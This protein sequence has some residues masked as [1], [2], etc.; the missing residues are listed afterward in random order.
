[1]SQKLLFGFSALFLIAILS[2]QVRAQGTNGDPQSGVYGE[3]TFRKWGQM[4]GNLVNTPFI[5][6]GM[7]GNWPNNPDPA[8][9]PKGSGHTYVEGATPIV[10]AE[11]VDRDG[12]VV[13]IAEAGYREDIDVGPTGTPWGYEPRPGWDGKNFE[14]GPFPFG[15]NITPAMSNKPDSWPDVWPDKFGPEFADDPGWPGAWNGFFGKN[16]FNADLETFFVMDDASDREFNYLPVP[17]DPNRG[18]LGTMV[19]ARGLQWSQVLAEDV[20]F[21]V[22]KIYNIS[23]F[24]LGVV[25]A[26]TEPKVFFGMMF[27]YGIGGLGDSGD[28]SAFYD[29]FIDISYGFDRD[30]KGNTGFSPTAYAGFA[31]LESP[32]NP[33]DNEDNDDDGFTDETRESGPGDKIEG[34]DNITNYIQT[35]YDVENLTSFFGLEIAE[36]PAVKSGILWTG[37]EDLDWVGFSDL[38]SNGRWDSTNEPLNNDVGADGISN[39]DPGY[40]G[41]DFGEGDGMPTAG[42][43]NFDATDLD[44]SDQIGLT[45]VHIFVTHDIT[46]KTDDLIWDSFSNKRFVTDIQNSLA[47]L[48]YSSGGFSLPKGSSQ[49][50]SI[51]MLF[52]ENLD[53]LF[54]N[55]ITVQAIFNANYNFAKPPLKPFVSAVPGDGK[56]TLYWDRRAEESVD[57]FLINP[58]TGRPGAKDFEGYK[59][60]RSTEPA[61]LESKNIT[62]A[63]GN[64]TFR[65]AIATFDLVNGIKG[66]APVRVNGISFDLGNDSGLRHSFV[67]STVENGQTYYY[68]V[69]SY[70]RGAPNLGTTGLPPSESSSVIDIDAFGNVVGTDVNT[71][72][73]TPNPKVPGYI[74]PFVEEGSLKPAGNLITGSGIIGSGGIAGIKVLDE[75]LV[76]DRT[77]RVTF[78]SSD[79]LV[80]FDVNTLTPAQVFLT[81]SY[82]V[83]DVT[84]GADDLKISASNALSIDNEGP[85]FD[86][87]SLVVDNDQTRLDTTASAW[88]AGD[89]DFE[90]EI[91]LSGAN[92]DKQILYP[93]DYEI[94]FADGAVS[95]S[96]NNRPANFIIWN[97]TEDRE[98]EFRFQGRGEWK[99]GNFID[100][101]ETIDGEREEI[102]RITLR[103]PGA[104]IAPVEG[105]IYLLST[106]K[107]FRSGDSFE[108]TTKK[109]AVDQTVVKAGLGQIAVVPNPYISAAS[110]ER[111]NFQQSG[112]GERKIY[113]INLPSRATIRIFTIAGKLV[114]TIEHDSTVDDDFGGFEGAHSW[115]MRT[116]EGLDIAFGVYVYH[117]KVDGVGQKIGKFAVIK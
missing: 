7:V 4:N 91:T 25:P 97:A 29:T 24:D 64:A 14:R 23:A 108:F 8:E 102:W 83:T 38:N 36:F 48:L 49:S 43:P 58:E 54:R 6:Y 17:S 88:I 46:P 99:S 68:A 41:P 76:V 101:Q 5:N 10:I 94:R 40:P 70:D 106:D 22:Y 18:G 93:A 85:V 32:G 30:N 96:T 2:S 80:P 11:V 13:H 75:R 15:R 16:Q 111:R 53:D 117:V 1:M 31:F 61:F 74:S 28:D 33:F 82:S 77:Y 114:D 107:P 109:A 50:F 110:W 79:E 98:S 71:V 87:L 52:G 21:W 34:I 89:S 95:T 100:I 55:K 86:G 104:G 112:R 63:F 45:G 81:T 92:F 19:T 115:D 78:Q 84:N 67:D 116:R 72:V 66:P 12:N 69:V 9:W 42:E 20:V 35:N 113:F 26:G 44:E 27:D 62:D 105:D 65:T 47:S 73:V 60:Y 39:F 59:I 37:D 90:F 51:A 56:V 103:D 57:L 3:R